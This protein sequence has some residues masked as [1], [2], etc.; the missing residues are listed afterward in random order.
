M[1]RSFP[2]LAAAGLCGF[3][4][5]AITTGRVPTLTQLSARNRWLGPVLV[6][7]LAVH[8]YRACP[9][10]RPVADCPLCPEPF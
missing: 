8:L 6:V 5:V 7:A 3:E 1:L 10:P 9:P 2:K 4:V